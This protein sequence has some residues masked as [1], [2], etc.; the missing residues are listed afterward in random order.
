MV[1]KRGRNQ[2]LNDQAEVGG[3]IEL[4][5][6]TSIVIA[7][8]NPER[9]VFHVN[10]NDSLRSCWIKL[11]PAAADDD[12]KGIYLSGSTRD[13]AKSWDM[14]SDNIYTGEISAI[15]EQGTPTVYVTEY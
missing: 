13:G 5:S 1:Q 8:A 4:N 7:A 3:G 9:T 11:Q 15:A 6:T 12:K 14:P 10:N 2:N